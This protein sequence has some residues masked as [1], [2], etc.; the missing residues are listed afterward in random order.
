M[1][2]IIQ[3][4]KHKQDTGKNHQ[5]IRTMLKTLPKDIT[6]PEIA[7][8]L[9]NKPEIALLQ[10][11]IY[12]ELKPIQKLVQGAKRYIEA[13]KQEDPKATR[14]LKEIG[15]RLCPFSKNA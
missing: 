6:L 9:D 12:K 15:D 3:L 14:L 1:A 10:E 4:P 8:N 13:V 2:K 7:A 11:L 5:Q